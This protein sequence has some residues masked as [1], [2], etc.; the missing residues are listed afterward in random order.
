MKKEEIISHTYEY[1]KEMLKDNDIAHDFY[2]V[3]RVIKTSFEIA[4]NYKE[5]DIFLLHMLA[6][7]HDIDDDKLA[8]SKNA[9][10]VKDFLKSINCPKEISEKILSILP[11]MSFRKYPILDEDFPI[12]GKIVVDADRLDAIGAIGIARVFSYSSFIKRPFYSEDEKENTAIKHF[13]EKLL[14]LHNY[15]NTKEAKKMA[16]QRH[17]II[18]EFYDEFLKEV[19]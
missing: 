7:L 3:E 17:K 8:S 19:K 11:K 9:F 4:S 6:L 18:K 1:V 2:H 16:I 14:I 13:D 10:K 12:E 5:V 15:L